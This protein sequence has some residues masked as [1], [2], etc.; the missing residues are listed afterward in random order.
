MANKYWYATSYSPDDNGKEQPL[1]FF[2]KKERNAWIDLTGARK[3]TWKEAR[4]ML[5]WKTTPEGY[6]GKFIK[7]F[8]TDEYMCMVNAD[9]EE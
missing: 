6:R 9:K 1:S 5:S 8:G 2:N 3:L 4:A 7:V